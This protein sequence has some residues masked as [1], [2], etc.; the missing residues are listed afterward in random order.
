MAKM[1]NCKTCGQRCEESSGGFGIF[2]LLFGFPFTWG[3]SFC[4]NNCKREWAG[5]RIWFGK[6][7]LTQSIIVA[8]LAVVAICFLA[9]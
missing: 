6:K 3:A 8:I 9:K 5:G 7:W 2:N 4:C 1:T